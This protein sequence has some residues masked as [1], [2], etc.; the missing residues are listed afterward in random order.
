MASKSQAQSILQEKY[1]INKSISESFNQ[2]E[3]E[4]L[5]IILDAEPI[6]IKLV[7]SLNLQN[8]KLM[9]VNSQLQKDNKYLKNIV[10]QIKLKLTADIKN[11]LKSDSEIRKGLIKLLQSIQG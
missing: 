10:D 6:A 4:K 3:C 1:G 9:E 8:K 2:E 7:E 5:L 11:L